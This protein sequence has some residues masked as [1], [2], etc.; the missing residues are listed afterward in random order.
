MSNKLLAMALAGS[1]GTLSRY[2]LSEALYAVLGR[3]FPW[4]TYAVNMLGCLLYGLVWGL[5]VDRALINDEIRMVILVGFMG[6][7]T[8]FSSLIF[9]SE[10]LLLEHRWLALAANLMGQNILGFAALFAGRMLARLV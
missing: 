2:G 4:G 1:L 9:D 7:F 6:S 10:V 8:T 3:S 5:S